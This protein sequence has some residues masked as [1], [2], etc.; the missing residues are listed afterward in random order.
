M[1]TLSAEN[2]QPPPPGDPPVQTLEPQQEKDVHQQEI[3]VVAPE[4]LYSIFTSRQKVLIVIMT[5]LS[6]L[7]SPLSST[8]YL[9][10]LPLLAKSL[11]TT[12]AHINLT[13]TSYMIFQGLAP[14]FFSSLSDATGRRPV[15]VLAFTIY[16]FANL[17]LTLQISY[18]ALFVLRAMQSVGS[19]ATIALGNGVMSDVVTSAERGG[20]IAWVSLGTQLG[21]ALAPTIEGL[22]GQYVG[23][24]AIFWFL[25]IVGGVYLT[26]YVFFV[27]ETARAVVGD[28]S[29]DP[30]KWGHPLVY[31]ISSKRRKIN[32]GDETPENGVRGR[33]K[34][35]RRGPNLL[36]SLRIIVEKD[37][38]CMLFVTSILVTAANCCIVILPTQYSSVYHL[39]ELQIGLCYM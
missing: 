19:S 8:I 32:E 3:P 36:N 31:Y 6:S 1:S 7:F 18:A 26:V 21:P 5:A 4:P 16:F 25:V 24:R 17:G 9:P 29:G 11:H 20:Y 38:F 30:G 35:K 2:P 10:I 14:L 13:V 28:G 22:L 37:V 27:P 15:Y 23:W 33:K 12:T 39:T 34:M